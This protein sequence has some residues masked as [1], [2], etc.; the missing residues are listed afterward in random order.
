MKKW[1]IIYNNMLTIEGTIN[2][3]KEDFVK[4]FINPCKESIYSYHLKDMEI[5]KEESVMI[6]EELIRQL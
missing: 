1:Y 5:E 3:S 6:L 2:C 4:W